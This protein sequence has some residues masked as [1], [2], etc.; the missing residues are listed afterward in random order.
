V[1]SKDTITGFEQLLENNPGWGAGQTVEYLRHVNNIFI[2]TFFEGNVQIRKENC[3]EYF[4]NLH[5]EMKFFHNWEQE[6]DLL[7]PTAEMKNKRFLQ[8]KQKKMLYNV[9]YGFESFTFYMLDR[10]K[11]IEGVY[12]SPKRCTQNCVEKFFGCVKMGEAN[13]NEQKLD[14]YTAVQRYSGSLD[15]IAGNV[16]KL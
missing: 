3:H 11:H 14:K 5:N 9:I 4:Q 16:H 7:Y 8:P 2:K 6:C 1:F 12:V 13:T 10:Y 15:D